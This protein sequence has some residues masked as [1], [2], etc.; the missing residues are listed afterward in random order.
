MSAWAAS[1]NLPGSFTGSTG[2][3]VLSADQLAPRNP[4]FQAWAKKVWINY[5][6]SL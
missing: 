4:R 5:F 1:K 2:A 6:A 3:R